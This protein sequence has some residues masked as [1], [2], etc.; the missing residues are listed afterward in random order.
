MSSTVQGH[1]DP[2]FARVRAVFEE[3]FA[4][5]RELGA[6]VAVYAGD[7][8]VVDLWGGVADRRTGR[9]WQPDTPC[10][11]FSCTKAV[12]AAAALL[13]A[14]RGAYDVDGPVTDWWPEFGAAGKDGAT[15][16]HLLSHQVGLPA[17][18]RPI[19]AEEAADAPARAAELAAQEPEWTPGEGHGYHALTYGWLAGEIVRRHSGGRTVGA[20]VKDEFARDLDLWVGAPDEVIERAAKLSAGRRTGGGTDAPR[21]TEHDVLTRLAEAYTD[22]R[23]M[24]NR[25]LNNPHP[26]KGGYNNPV[27]LRAGWPAAGMTTTAP[28]LAGFY[29]DLTAGRI[30]RPDTLR[31]AVRPRVSGPDR[32]L[33][34][35]SSFGLGF[36]RPSQTFFTPRAGRESAFGHTGA[37]GSVGLGDPEAGLA[38]AY[39]P[40]LMGDQA[41]GD[42]RAYR[43]TQAAYASLS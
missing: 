5:G 6:A 16:E 43:L 7:R 8:K 32:T 22:P 36:M 24:M 31:E 2:A 28:A 14:E 37:G 35:R 4:E 9:A 42:L 29:R 19:S 40:N 39:L 17:F 30:L 10:F 23:S 1:C 12:T 13:L 34:V 20:F 18:A 27:V 3:H 41:S 21:T 38:L 26:G 15:A 33:L 25:S 11:G